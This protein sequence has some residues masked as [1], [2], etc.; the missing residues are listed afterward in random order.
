MGVGGSRERRRWVGSDGRRRISF[1]EGRAAMEVSYMPNLVAE[2]SRAT[3]KRLKWW[4]EGWR[5]S[6][7]TGR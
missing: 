4:D 2:K 6:K 3:E 1:L 5:G 7:R